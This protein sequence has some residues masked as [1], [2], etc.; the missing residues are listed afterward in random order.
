MVDYI[1]DQ[2]TLFGGDGV[3]GFGDDRFMVRKV[4]RDIANRI[5]K[6]HHYSGTVYGLSDIHLE[7]LISGRRAG[8]LQFGPGMNPGSG[9]SV[10]ANT[11]SGQWLELNRM[12]L[13]DEAPRN[14]ESQAIAYAIKLIRRMRPAVAWIQSFA[15]ERC[16]CYGVVYQAANALYCGEHTSIFWELDGKWYHNIAATVRGED[17]LRTRKGAAHLQANLARA[18]RHDLRQFRYIFPLKR[19]VLRDLLLPVLPYPKANNG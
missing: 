16:G 18:T 13:D 7:V 2:L 3:C 6:R 8:I 19:R 15:D 12:W 17:Q 11:D 9:A 4:D 10:V 14:S 1:V 5:I